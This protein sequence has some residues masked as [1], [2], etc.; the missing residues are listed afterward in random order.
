MLK[1]DSATFRIGGG[2]AVSGAEGPRGEG[3]P[4]LPDFVR[5]LGNPTRAEILRRLSHKKGS[6]TTLA[7]E[8]N[9]PVPRVSYHLIEILYEKERYVELV[10]SRSVGSLEER[11]FITSPQAMKGAIDWPL[12]PEPF[13][14]SLLWEP[15]RL[16]QRA[17]IDAIEVDDLAT[18]DDKTLT[19]RSGVLDA[20]GWQEAK[21]LL[22]KLEVELDRIFGTTS[23]RLDKS[24]LKQIPVHIGV[25]AFKFQSCPPPGNP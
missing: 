10:D 22:A 25:T 17:L 18:T 9:L 13:R 1:G 19:W 20:R 3:S 7:A 15:L 24:D 21:N 16:F 11:F 2:G 8:L 23:R 6:A 12:V 5:V 14:S 4:F